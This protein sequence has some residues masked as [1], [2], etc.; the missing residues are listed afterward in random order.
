MSTKLTRQNVDKARALPDTVVPRVSVN[1]SAAVKMLWLSRFQQLTATKH[2]SSLVP[3]CQGLSLGLA[4]NANEHFVGSK[5][6]LP[7]VNTVLLYYISTEST[8]V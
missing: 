1:E 6:K 8:T 7:L 2:T 5:L 4:T 3:G